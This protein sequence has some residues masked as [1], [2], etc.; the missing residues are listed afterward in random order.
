MPMAA[1]QPL[2]S[3]AAVEAHLWALGTFLYSAVAVASHC[4]E[5][6]E[7]ALEWW[8]A[9]MWAELAGSAAAVLSLLPYYLSER[10]LP[11]VGI[12]ADGSISRAGAK[13]VGGGG[14][15]AVVLWVIVRRLAGLRRKR[16]APE[17][18]G[19]TAP[20]ARALSPNTRVEDWL[21]SE[22]LGACAAVLGQLGYDQRIDLL[23]VRHTNVALHSRDM[24]RCAGSPGAAVA[25]VHTQE[26]DVD[27]LRDM[28]R[29]VYGSTSIPKPIARKFERSLAAL[30]T[31]TIW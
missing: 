13:R 19:E 28:L 3:L 5:R 8:R 2:G 23:I 9:T 12:A 21:A 20:G 10:G 6:W 17:G 14:V 24:L 16:S 26:S 27:E 30:R 15:G 22:G 11:F 31:T 29:A 18:Q 4:G 25:G 7:Q 1:F